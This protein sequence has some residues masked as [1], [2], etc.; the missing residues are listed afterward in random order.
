MLLRGVIPVSI[1]KREAC[2]YLGYGLP[3]IGEGGVGRCEGGGGGGGKG[4]QLPAN[5]RLRPTVSTDP[6]WSVPALVAAALGTVA[7]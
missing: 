6:L 7:G 3:C 2:H 1:S 5:N 4:K